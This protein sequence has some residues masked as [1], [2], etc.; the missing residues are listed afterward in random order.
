ML[1]L[2]L[3]VVMNLH[4][5]ALLAAFVFIEKLATSGLWLSRVSDLFS[6]ARMAGFVI[7]SLKVPP[8][9]QPVIA[10]QLLRRTAHIPATAN[11]GQLEKKKAAESRCHRGLLL[12]QLLTCLL[13]RR[14]T[15][16]CAKN[17]R[18]H[19]QRR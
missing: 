16:K 4:W 2:F 19:L 14:G 5:I 3:L 1:L 6:L 10:S 12:A 18:E 15:R 7:P 8:A 17:C 9:V 13:Q 11:V